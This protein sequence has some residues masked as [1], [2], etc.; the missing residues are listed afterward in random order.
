MKRQ[1]KVLVC[2]IVLI[3]QFHFQ[4]ELRGINTKF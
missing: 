1:G 3:K 4:I 2:I